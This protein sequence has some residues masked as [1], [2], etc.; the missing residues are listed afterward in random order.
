M[1]PA[2]PASRLDVTRRDARK[3]GAHGATVNTW[4]EDGRVWVEWRDAQKKKHTKSWPEAKAPE[5]R[6]WAQLYAAER[7]R[8]KKV[9]GPVPTLAE[10]WPRY[11]SAQGPGWRPKSKR[12]AAAWAKDL[13]RVITKPIDQ[14]THDD[15]DA[16]R[17]ARRAQGIAHGTIRRALGFLRQILA[18][19]VGRRLVAV[20]PLVTY[21]YVTPK[22][23]RQEPPAEY[24]RGEILAM[25]QVLHR[26]S[27]WRPRCIIALCE[28]YGARI[29]AILHLK[30]ADVNLTAG[31]VTFR[32]EW[33]KMGETFT[34]PMTRAARA[35]I[36]EALTHPHESGWLFWGRKGPLTYNAAW[37][38]L[39]KAERL[40]GVEHQ[41]RRAFHGARRLVIGDIGDL[42][43]AGVWV[44][45]KKLAVTQGYMR[46]RPEQVEQA[47]RRLER[48]K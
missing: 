6:R 28:S 36:E 2:T 16:F 30:R 11:L 19:A 3:Y 42:Q 43:L 47:K 18:F 14:I 17:D 45:Q 33:D 37:Y 46:E 34:R 24:T 10:L 35:A 12:N 7:E 29:N 44:N 25:L 32:G 48:G 13:S 41:Q 22:N 20:H 1:W 38:H 26:P 8:L 40:A 23:E 5:A 27:E 4:L 9:E 31:E 39:R 15:A 21:R